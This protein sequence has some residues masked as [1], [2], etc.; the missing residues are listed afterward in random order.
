MYTTTETRLTEEN[1]S[2]LAA[3]ALSASAVSWG[4]VFAGATAAAS[5]SLILLIL[6]T[7]LGMSSVSPWAQEGISAKTFGISTILWI[8]FMSFAASAIGGYI[9][10]RL[11]TKWVG[12]HTHEVFF[13]DTAHG[14]LAWGVA[15]LAT[16]FFLTSVTAAIVTGGVKAGAAVA[17]GA[18]STASATTAVVTEG[19]DE[20]NADRTLNYFI[21]SLFRSDNREAQ[22]AVT[23]PESVADQDTA[24][25]PGAASR[26]ERNRTPATQASAS[27]TSAEVARIFLN[28]FWRN[29]D[30]SAEDSRYIAQL[31]AQRTNLTL[32]EAEQRVRDTYARLQTRMAEMEKTAKEAADTARATSA[33]ASLW[34]FVALLLGAFIASLAATFGGRQRDL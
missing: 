33:Y 14:F 12:V 8:T 29:E 3:G 15:T 30:L 32:Q 18:A 7:G 34:F 24:T 16:A 13:R 6:G 22:G 31:V 4:A 28:A 9:A 17:S 21:D 20:Q 11:R 2:T 19:I 27:E 10:G 5:L 1:S 25:A 23:Q 26:L